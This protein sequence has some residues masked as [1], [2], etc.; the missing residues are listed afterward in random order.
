LSYMFDASSIL[1]LTREL[2]E[3]VVDVMKGN[4]TSSLAYYEVGNALWKKC[5]LAKK[6]TLNEATEVLEFTLSLF[7]LM[8][9]VHISDK[10][11]GGKT[12][13]NAAKLNITYY[14]AAYLTA[15]KETG[16][17]LVSDDKKLTTASQK[18]GVKTLP[19]K[20]FIDQH[21]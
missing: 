14:D 11:M 9:I 15:A 4:L 2:E 6:L 12:L 10:D 3:K 7:K 16:K 21:K 1:I 17:V 20:A 8:K 18:I 19:S 13:S 5:N